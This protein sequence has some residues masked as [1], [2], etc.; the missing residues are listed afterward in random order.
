MRSSVPVV[1]GQKRPVTPTQ[2]AR[3]LG[4]P[5]DAVSVCRRLRARW[6]GWQ[7]GWCPASADRPA[8]YYAARE[9][10]WAL[11]AVV[12]G[13]TEEELAA[14]IRAHKL[15]TQGHDCRRS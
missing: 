2:I 8:T 14:A 9:W 4:W 3:Y 1:G 12:Y 5:R 6:P 10:K 11:P 15:T 13:A 7:V